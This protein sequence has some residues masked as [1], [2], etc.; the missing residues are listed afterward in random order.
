[1]RTSC[2]KRRDNASRRSPASLGITNIPKCESAGIVRGRT[3]H[4]PWCSDSQM[5]SCSR[6]PADGQ[7]HSSSRPVKY[8]DALQQISQRRKR[9]AFHQRR[10]GNAKNPLE[11]QHSEATDR[12][13]AARQPPESLHESPHGGHLRDRTI[14]A[15]APEA[16]LRIVSRSEVPEARRQGSR[17]PLRVLIAPA[18]SAFLALLPSGKRRSAYFDI[19]NFNSSFQVLRNILKERLFRLQLKEDRVEQV[20]SQQSNGFLLQW[21]GRI[22][23]V[24]MENDF[25]HFTARL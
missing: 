23:Q 17:S 16:F 12:G 21:I 1:M 14:L 18:R 8:I 6:V 11:Q 7:E 3:E 10:R 24:D 19:V 5:R 2:V 25:V 9:V 22:L 4:S 20:H 13:A 15:Q